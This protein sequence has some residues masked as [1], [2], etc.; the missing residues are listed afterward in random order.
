MLSTPSQNGCH[1]VMPPLDVVTLESEFVRLE[2]LTLDH[3]AAMVAAASTDEPHTFRFFCEAC[4]DAGVETV[5]SVDVVSALRRR[6][7]TS[8]AH[9]SC[10]RCGDAHPRQFDRP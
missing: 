9:I 8:A 4:A 6:F 5:W 10:P 3:T 7:V 1:E 2:Q